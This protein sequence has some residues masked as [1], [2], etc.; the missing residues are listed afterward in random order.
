VGNGENIKILGDK[1]LPSPTSHT[2]Q[3]PV[4]ILNS[5]AKVWELIDQDTNWWNISL[6]KEIFMEE[7]V[8]MICGLAICPGTQQDRAVSAGSKNGLFSVRSAYHLAKEM[9]NRD[10]GGCSRRD[11]LT[12]LWNKIWRCNVP[13]VVKLFLWQACNNVLPTKENL[14]K[15]KI[16]NDPL[17]PVCSLEIETAGHA[18]WSCSGAWDVWTEMSAKTQKSISEEDEF[19]YILMRLMNR[20]EGPDFDK[21]LC[22]ARQIWIRRNKLVFEGEFTHPRV[23]ARAAVDQLEFHVKV[24]QGYEREEQGRQIEDEK[25]SAPRPDY[26]KINWNAALDHMKKLMGV[27]VVV[28][29]CTGGVVATQ[30]STRPYINDSTVAE[31]LAFWTAANL[32]HQ[33]GLVEAILEG[34]SLEIVNAVAKEGE[35]WSNYGPV[36]EEAK[37]VLNGRYPWEVKHVRRSANKAAHTIAKW[38]VA[39]NINQLWLTTTPPCIRD[40]VMAESSFIE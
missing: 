36:V 16:T 25:W 23:V 4:H 17:C 31:A 21:L 8:E 40:I 39:D 32:R 35:V 24:N 34:D 15:R 12:D 29:D 6:I 33:L 7:E 11:V 13:R 10:K 22:A 28:R 1:W 3:S 37:G 38:A 20:L 18:L 27:G 9:E 2:I 14:Y 19:S 30:C 26:V 5:E